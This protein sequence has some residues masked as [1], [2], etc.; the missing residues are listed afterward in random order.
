MIKKD[1]TGLIEINVWLNIIKVNLGVLK[2]PLKKGINCLL[3][4]YIS[5]LLKILMLF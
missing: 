1:K 4:E 2:E 3:K 5:F